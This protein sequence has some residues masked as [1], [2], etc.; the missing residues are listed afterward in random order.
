MKNSDHSDNNCCNIDIETDAGLIRADIK[1]ER[2]SSFTKNA[3][4][5][6]ILCNQIRI[7]DK[8]VQLEKQD[9]KSIIG[10]E[11]SLDALISSIV[12]ADLHNP[13]RIVAK[14][15]LSGIVEQIA[16]LIDFIAK[17][18]DNESIIRQL[19]QLTAKQ[20]IYENILNNL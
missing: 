18:P 6:P 8:K 3:S 12:P 16:D 10:S 13:I 4:Q 2:L 5:N 17:D 15:K 20:K 11:R 9:Y 14:I 19:S 7:L 1:R